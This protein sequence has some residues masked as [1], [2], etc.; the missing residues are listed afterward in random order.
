MT[1][2]GWQMFGAYL[3]MAAAL[4]FLAYG[5]YS[6]CLQGNSDLWWAFQHV[7]GNQC[8]NLLRELR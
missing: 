2:F 7:T 3:V 8:W 1:R 5:K 6:P 4:V